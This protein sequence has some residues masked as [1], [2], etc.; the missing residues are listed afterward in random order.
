VLVIED[1]SDTRDALGMLLTTWNHEVLFAGS[2][3]E[4][5]DRARE[6]RPTSRSSTSGCRGSTATRSRG[7][8]RREGSLWSRQVRL[9]ALTGYG[10]EDDRA[11][12][13]SAGFD[14]HVLK[15]V[16]PMDCGHSRLS[17][18]LPGGDRGTLPSTAALG[19][20][21]RW[22]CFSPLTFWP[23][24]RAVTAIRYARP[25][26]ALAGLRR[27]SRAIRVFPRALPPRLSHVLRLLGEYRHDPAGGLIPLVLTAWV[28]WVVNMEHF[29]L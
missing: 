21:V 5:L 3:P 28:L 4:G 12:A 10:Q 26:R 11:R 24:I 23:S 18:K 22:P 15:P 2:G 17:R 7:G 6:L 25:C 19:V 16:D 9:I 8:I 1:G 29:H 13:L 27:R 20:M 14:V